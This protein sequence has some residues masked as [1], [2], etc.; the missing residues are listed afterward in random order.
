MKQ[1]DITY[2]D[3][4]NGLLFD[5][6][7]PKSKSLVFVLLE[8]ESD[9]KLFRK[10]FNEDN[11][12]LSRVPPGGKLKVFDCVNDL[13]NKHD[14]VLGIVDADFMHL[15]NEKPDHENIFL[16]DYHDIE[17][18]FFSNDDLFSSILSEH[19]K[20]SK[21]EHRQVRD[22][23]LAILENVGY[24]KWLND[25]EKPKFN[26]NFS[27][28]DLIDF[29]KNE[30]E[31]EKYFNR[32]LSKSQNPAIEDFNIVIEAIIRL[33]TRNSDLY[34]LCNGHDFLKV[35]AEYLRK[36]HKS[37]N[38]NEENLANSLRIAYSK[39]HYQQTKLYADTQNWAT[40]KNVVIYS[41]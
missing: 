18:I 28:V 15:N 38:V 23:I 7:N 9:I 3:Y 33:K 1:Q 39:N 12:I 13:H 5:I 26:F 32:V 2:Q 21:G 35:F 34:H 41:N 36:E 19:T 14:L 20:L 6:Q 30:I 29:Q 24:L 27:F 37:A 8:G 4:L 11:C 22:N 40:N 31:V 10:F 16:T 17:M 25:L